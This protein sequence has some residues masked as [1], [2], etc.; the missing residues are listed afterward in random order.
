MISIVIP[1]LDEESIIKKTLERL[2]RIKGFDLEIIVSDG[3]SSDK[4]VELAAALADKVVVYDGVERQTIADGR[5]LGAM[6]AK[7]EFLLFLDADVSLLDGENFLR[8]LLERFSE[9]QE[10]IAAT[11]RIKVLPQFATLADK[12]LSILMIDTPHFFNNNIFKF[13][14]SSGEVQFIRKA[15]FDQVGGFNGDLV[16]CEDLDMFE[17]LARV[18]KTRFFWN[19]SVHHTG[20]RFHK[21]GWARVLYTWIV[22]IIYFR[23]AGRTRSKEW[24]VVR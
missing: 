15:A 19:L 20:R 17:R 7:G 22:N 10:L 4:T 1:V 3:K 16:S 13:G 11:T 9:D 21:M 18:G 14:S 5:N 24:T 2:R 12:I 8:I 23:I 6:A